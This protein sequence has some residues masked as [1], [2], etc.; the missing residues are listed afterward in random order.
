MP[1]ATAYYLKGDL[2]RVCEQADRS[3]GHRSVI[4]NY[5]RYR[6]ST[7]P[8]EGT[9]T[10]IPVLQRKT[11]GFR[12]AEFFKLK[13]YAL[14]KT[15]YKRVGSVAVKSIH[16]PDEPDLFCPHYSP[17]TKKDRQSQTIV[18]LIFTSN[19]QGRT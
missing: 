19:G 14:P 13:I 4:L 12:D 10:K 17:T 3:A 8:Q 16:K 5:Y 7:G 2:R 6:I 9:N 11:Y 15:R 18:S 1:R